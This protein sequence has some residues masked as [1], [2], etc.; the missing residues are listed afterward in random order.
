MGP[1]GKDYGSPKFSKE[2]RERKLSLE[3]LRDSSLC[4]TQA[5]R[6]KEEE[7]PLTRGAWKVAWL[8]RDRPARLLARM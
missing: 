3:E 7:P 5:I 4:C 2:F 1:S 8:G 6:W